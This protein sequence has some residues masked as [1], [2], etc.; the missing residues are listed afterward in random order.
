[1]SKIRFLPFGP[2]QKATFVKQ[3]ALSQ[4]LYASEAMQMPEKPL[5]A[6]RTAIVDVMVPHGH[7]RSAAMGFSIGSR[8]ND[9]DP[10]V[11]Q[12]VLKVKALRNYC[13]KVPNALA[14]IHTILAYYA[15]LDH[16]GIYIY[17]LMIMPYQS[18]SQPRLQLDPEVLGSTI[19]KPWDQ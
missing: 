1:M 11:V 8:G 3:C 18:C 10:M 4:A 9:L 12:L 5:Q 6:L 19:P 2:A 16:H 7:K 13:Y 15:Q 14:K 17:I